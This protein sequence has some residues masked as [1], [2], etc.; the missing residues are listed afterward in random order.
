VLISLLLSSLILKSQ[1][2]NYDP[3]TALEPLK[4][5]M[6]NGYSLAKLLKDIKGE[7]VPVDFLGS[8]EGL[9]LIKYVD[10][11]DIEMKA[12]QARSVKVYSQ[13]NVYKGYIKF[14]I[15]TDSYGKK[16]VDTNAI[17]DYHAKINDSIVI[18]ESI[19][20]AEAS[21]KRINGGVRILFRKEGE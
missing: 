20:T 17:V 4:N 18:S 11:V 9:N 3:S 19:K 13:D 5:I 6:Y 7:K 12:A 10:S 2:S 21:V 8:K 14:A 16:N 1:T 15:R